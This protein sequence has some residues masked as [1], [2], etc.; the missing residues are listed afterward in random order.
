M[1]RPSPSAQATSSPAS[2]RCRADSSLALLRDGVSTA[3]AERG[4]A[5]GDSDRLLELKQ[6]LSRTLAGAEAPREIVFLDDRGRNAAGKTI[7]REMR[8]NG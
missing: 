1:Q 5:S 7:R 8:Q 4:G 3:L 2:A 6:H